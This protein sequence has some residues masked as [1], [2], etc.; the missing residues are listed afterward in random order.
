[1]EIKARL[2]FVIYIVLFA[3]NLMEHRSFFSLSLLL[4]PHLGSAYGR[5]QEE[6]LNSEEDDGGFD[7][8]TR[9]WRPLLAPFRPCTATGNDAF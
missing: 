2:P 1:M 8:K 3:L 9:G 5:F 6:T 7:S 4:G